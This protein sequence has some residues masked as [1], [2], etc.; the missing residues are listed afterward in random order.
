M[1]S[2]QRSAGADRPDASA[3]AEESA[4]RDRRLTELAVQVCCGADQ[5]QVC[6]GLGE[7]AQLLTR[8]ADLLGVKAEVVGVGKHF[9]E[10]KPRL[11]QVPSAG[12]GFGVPE[13]AHREGSLSAL[14]AVR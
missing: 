4:A 11:A 5:C 9:L 13:G 7:V 6:E 1:S 3:E 2:A 8:G 10:D 12:E 14:Q